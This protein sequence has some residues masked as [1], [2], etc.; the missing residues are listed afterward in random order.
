MIGKKVQHASPRY[1]LK[2]EIKCIEKMNDNKIEV[3]LKEGDFYYL[4]TKEYEIL[5]TK[6]KVYFSFNGGH[7]FIKIIK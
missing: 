7:T 6:G 4:T 5:K 2:G 3:T 1:P